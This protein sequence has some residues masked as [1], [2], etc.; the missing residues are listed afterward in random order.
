MSHNMPRG[1][2][3]ALF[4][5]EHLPSDWTSKTKIWMTGGA[6]GDLLVRKEILKTDSLTK[7]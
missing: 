2:K 6:G 1:Q 5:K 3:W 4:E 7:L